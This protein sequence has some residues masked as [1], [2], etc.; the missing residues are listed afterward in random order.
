L[1]KAVMYPVRAVANLEER[2]H[3]TQQLYLMFTSA[4]GTFGVRPQ[5]TWTLSFSPF[6]G[7]TF[8]HHRM[9][10]VGTTFDVTVEGGFSP[11]LIQTRVHAR[12]TPWGRAIQL[13][14]TTSFLRRDDQ[15]FT[16][17]GM[18]TLGPSRYLLNAFDIDGFLRF[19][20]RPE[21]RLFLGGHFG[22]RRY[23]DGRQLGDEPPV[24]KLYCVRTVSGLCSQFVDEN[25]VPGFFS[26]T[27]FLRGTAGFAVDTRDVSFKPTSGAL[28]DF[29]AD[30][31][32]G[33]REPSSYFR[34]RGS[35]MGVLDLWKR[36]HVLV[37]RAFAMTVV[38]TNGEPVPFTELAVL[39]GWD[40]LRGVRWGRF[41]DFSSVLFTAEYRWPVWMWM[42]AVLFAD[43]GGV[44]GKGW[45]G[46]AVD[47]LVPDVGVGLRIR[48]SRTFYFRLQT[49]WSPLEGIQFFFSANAVP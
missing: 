46:F 23:A 34:F 48:T 40:D 39:G 45:S 31:S 3:I 1:W 43:A 9:L 28:V 47:K 41:R 36:S 13:D 19:I 30:Y 42:D 38:P 5:I 44:F 2:H 26:G 25:L 21:A 29:S 22:L 15:L 37:I 4:D 33:L 35:L 8:F 32:H 27:E 49:A 20:V 6:F 10:G 7:A 17:I 14:L 12:P 11:D 24:S 16:G 18:E